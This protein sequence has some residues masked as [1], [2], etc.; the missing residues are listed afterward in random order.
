MPK[1]GLRGMLSLFFSQKKNIGQE[2]YKGYLPVLN[3][4]C[5]S[6]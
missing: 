4:N 3:N 2:T 1:K 6:K 5:H